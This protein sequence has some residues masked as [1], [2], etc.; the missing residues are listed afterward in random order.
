MIIDHIT[1]LQKKLKN[2]LNFETE[3]NI[4]DAVK[5]LCKAFDNGLLLDSLNNELY[6][7]IKNAEHISEVTL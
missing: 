6:F 5:D 3:H 4:Y 7:N 1:F 2:N